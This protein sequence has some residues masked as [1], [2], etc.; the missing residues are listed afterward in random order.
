MDKITPYNE[1]VSQLEKARF[2]VM[3]WPANDHWHLQW[4]RGGARWRASVVDGNNGRIIFET[5]GWAALKWIEARA[6]GDGDETRFATRLKGPR[7]AR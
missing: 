4:E 3:L 1:A 6:S 7:R 5:L 2:R